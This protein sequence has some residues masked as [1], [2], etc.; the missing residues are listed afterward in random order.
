M[1]ASRIHRL[2]RLVQ[3]YY[4]LTPL[5]LFLSWR[6]GFDVRVPFLDVVP[7]AR[8]AYYSLSFV[9]AALVTVRPNLTATVGR[10]EATLSVSLLIITTW[11]AYLGVLESAAS[12]AGTLHNPFTPQAV[13]SLV[14]S[15]AVFIA[16]SL[17]SGAEELRA[18]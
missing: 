2:A 4:W 11:I 7:G 15:A 9:C 5:F 8:V 13:T 18:A 1:P 12:D 6:F 10:A 17:L 16:S 14:L 3:G